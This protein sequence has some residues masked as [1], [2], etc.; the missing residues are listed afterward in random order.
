MLARCLVLALAACAASAQPALIPAPTSL[1]TGRGSFEIDGE[2]ALVVA[3]GDR[4]ARRVAGV[5]AALVGTTDDSTPQVTSARPRTGAVRFVTDPAR[6]DLG[7]E[8]YQLS[9]TRTGATL[10]AATPAGLFYGVQTIRQLLPPRVEHTANA[11][12]RAPDSRRRNHRPPALPVARDDAGRGPPLFRGPGRRARHRPYGALQAQPLAPPP[13]RRPGLAD[14]DPRLPRLDP[15]RGTNRGGR[16]PRRLLHDGRLRPDRGLR[17]PAVRHHRAR[18]RPARTHQRRAGVSPGAELRRRRSPALHR[19]PGRLQLGLRRPGGDLRLRRR[20]RGPTS[21]A[22]ARRRDPPGRRRG[23]KALRRR[24]RPV[25]A[26]RPGHRRPPRQ[27]DDGLGRDGE[28]PVWSPAPLSRSG[29][30]RC[31]A[32]RGALRARSAT[33][34]KSCCR[35]PTGST[36]T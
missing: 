35:P 7:A 19:H 18:D 15:R 4:E 12:A 8:G 10:T 30:P 11:A 32:P 28:R 25:Y 31:A 16:R 17:R 24:V 6:D 22:D 21:G 23:R 14:R 27:A 13:V 5:L 3:P 20:R 34:L 1:E 29:N 2:T 33:A 26:P 9:V 36:S